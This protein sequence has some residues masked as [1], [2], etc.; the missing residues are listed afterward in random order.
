MKD[1]G[2]AAPGEE[3]LPLAARL[4]APDLISCILGSPDTPASAESPLEETPKGLRLLLDG[5][6]RS[7]LVDRDGRP[8]E[9]SFPGGEVVT[10]RPGDGVPRRIEANGPDGRAVLTLESFGPWPAGEEVPPP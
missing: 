2:G 3:A 6:N 10:F 1:G 8:I 4:A 5:S 7:A 9:L